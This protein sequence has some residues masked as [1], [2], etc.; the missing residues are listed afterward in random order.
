[1][2]VDSSVARLVSLASEPSFTTT[3]R[4]GRGWVALDLGQLWR[5][6][7]LLYFLIWRDMKVRYKQTALGATWAVLQPLLTMA[8]FAVV[9]GHFARIP[10][11]GVPYAIFAYCALVPWTLFAYAMSQAANSL[12]AN[13]NLVARVYFPRLIIPVAA[14]LAGLLDFAIAFAVLL[15]MMVPYRVAPTAAILTLPLFLL[16]AMAAALAVG[17]WLAALNVQYR[18][19]RYTIIFLTQ[20]W[21]YATPITYPSSMI[22][23]RLHVLL[24][25]NPMTGVV[26]GF[27]RAILGT[28]GLDWISLAISSMVTALALAGGLI[29]FRR[30]EQRFADMM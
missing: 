1:M 17:I 19:V 16:L 15:I 4:P 8:I 13:A 5:Y 6:R 12:V 24:A 25:L 23:G 29:Y 7:E 21:L 10:S 27:R 2:P 14:A 30:M 20:I 11:D 18:D 26:E 28:G 22:K 3:V 9:F